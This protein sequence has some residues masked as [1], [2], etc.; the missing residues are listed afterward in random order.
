[1]LAQDYERLELVISDNASTDET[2][3][4][5]RK[6]ASTDNRIVYHRQIDNVGL[7]RNF[8]QT[9]NL[10]KGTFFRWMSDDDWLA[11]NYISRC[12]EAFL[13]D[14]RLILVTTQQNYVRSD[15]SSYTIAYSDK[16]FYS[17]DPIHRLEN[18]ISY[19]ISGSLPIDPLYG[20]AWRASLAT[21][22]R[23][24]MIRED[25]VFAMRLTLAGPWGH[26]P[27]VLAKRNVRDYGVSATARYLGVP[28]WQ[29]YVPTAVQCWE[30]LRLLPAERITSS[31]RRRAR[32][33][34]GRLFVG[35]HYRTLIHRA[36]KVVDL[37]L[38]T[39]SAS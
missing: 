3:E 39:R 4:L 23:R 22:A 19:I 32:I 13:G 37:V 26:V 20:M 10:A 2:E 7:L 9:L 31:Q 16:A 36:R 1:V 18:L 24:N 14:S 17:D 11:P 12:M 21:M 34:V 38:P 28:I 8:V 27:E 6:L 29:A 35:R 33:A 15:G 30:M 25:E 5:C